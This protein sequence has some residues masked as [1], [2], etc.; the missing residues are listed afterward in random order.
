LCLS[1]FGGTLNPIV[2]ARPP[3]L[4]R[5]AVV[6]SIAS[7]LMILGL[8][9]VI[10]A[11]LDWDSCLGVIDLRAAGAALGDDNLARWAV[12]CGGMLLILLGLLC[13]L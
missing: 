9:A 7:V 4:R 11:L 2:P 3:D 12:G 6:F 8:W 13:T 1:A 10:A 5:R